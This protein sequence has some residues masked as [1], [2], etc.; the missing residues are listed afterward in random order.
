M[1]V[2]P[3]DRSVIASNSH[4]NGYVMFCFAHQAEP[5]V[6]TMNSAIFGGAIPR[7]QLG[8]GHMGKLHRSDDVLIHPGLWYSKTYLQTQQLRASAPFA[9]T[10]SMFMS[11]ARCHESSYT[12]SGASRQNIYTAKENRHPSIIEYIGRSF[13]CIIGNFSN[14]AIGFRGRPK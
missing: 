1:Y 13:F 11:T 4:R 6:T 5:M 12:H 14:S 7:R 10:Q 2:H 9:L 8:T 3:F